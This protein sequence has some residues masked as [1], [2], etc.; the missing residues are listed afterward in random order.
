[1]MPNRV[2][3]RIRGR[4]AGWTASSPSFR[5]A[6]LAMF[7][8]DGKEFFRVVAGPAD[9]EPPRH[10]AGS[11]GQTGVA[12]GANENTAIDSRE[13]GGSTGWNG[14][15]SAP[16]TETAVALVVV[17]D[18]VHDALGSTDAALLLQVVDRGPHVVSV[19]RGPVVAFRQPRPDPG[20]PS[21]SDHVDH[22]TLRTVV[23]AQGQ[24]SLGQDSSRK[25]HCQLP[26]TREVT[27]GD[28]GARV[29]RSPPRRSRTVSTPMYR[30]ATRR[31]IWKRRTAR[32]WLWPGPGSCECRSLRETAAASGSSPPP[33]WQ[34]IPGRF[35]SAT[36]G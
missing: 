3:A 19:P 17:L 4:L 5:L 15:R 12:V 36:C 22:E 7:G 31:R 24:E 18:L 2:G 35:S 10:E 9:S 29:Q 21:R 1:M 16:Q 33:T 32:P 20:A 27:S 14:D 13:Y 23:L 34:G 6:R 26:C 30:C 8:R 25:L 28:P 11:L